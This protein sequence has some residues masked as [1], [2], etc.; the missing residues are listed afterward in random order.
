MTVPTR[1]SGYWS[2]WNA[3]LRRRFSS[4]WGVVTPCWLSLD[5]VRPGMMAL[6]QI[7]SDPISRASARVNPNTPALDET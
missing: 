6:T 2:R 3:R 7:L 1:S 4:C 5:M